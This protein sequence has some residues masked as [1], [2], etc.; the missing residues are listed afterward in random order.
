MIL[1]MGGVPTIDATC[2]KN[3]ELLL[4]T[5][6]MRGVVLLLSHVTEPSQKVL[7]RAGFLE[8]LGEEQLVPTVSVALAIAQKRAEEPA[9]SADAE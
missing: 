9:P 6:R 3:L 4:A 5:C 7:R 8:K 1:R 2:M